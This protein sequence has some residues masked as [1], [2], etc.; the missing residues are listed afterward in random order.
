M[1]KGCSPRWAQSNFEAAFERPLHR[2]SMRGPAHDADL[3]SE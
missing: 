3:V 2:R 1:V